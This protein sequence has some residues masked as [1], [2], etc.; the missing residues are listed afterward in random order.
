MATILET[1]DFGGD[2]SRHLIL[3]EL[4]ER[5]I[6]DLAY[7][8]SAHPQ[9]TPNVLEVVLEKISSRSVFR[10]CFRSGSKSHRLAPCLAGVR[11]LDRI[12]VEKIDFVKEKPI[13]I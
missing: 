6:L 1:A 12:I 8:L 2:G 3:T 5:M 13:Q 9:F 4:L 7:S 10:V 11:F